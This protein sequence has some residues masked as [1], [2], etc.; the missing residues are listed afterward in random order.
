MKPWIG[1]D[2]DGTLAMH[3]GELTPLSLTEIGAP[4][5]AMVERVRNWLGEGK[6]I[7]IFTARVNPANRGNIKYDKKVIITAIETWC[8][9]YIGCVLPVTC[10]KDW[11]MIELWDDRCVQVERNVG[12][13]V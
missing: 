13:P 10:E 3:S 5:P 6:D 7:R 8:L 11:L 12:M 2:L 4:V 9:R 1:V